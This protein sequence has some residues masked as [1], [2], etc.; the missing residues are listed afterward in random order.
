M[1]MYG[2]MKRTAK[3]AVGTSRHYPGICLEILRTTINQDRQCY[4]P[5]LE[6]VTSKIQVTHTSISANLLI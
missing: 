1:I 4:Q 5:I 2:E 3:E 6:P